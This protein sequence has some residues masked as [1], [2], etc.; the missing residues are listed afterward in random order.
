MGEQGHIKVH[1]PLTFPPAVT[2]FR[3]GDE[4]KTYNTSYDGWGFVF[5]AQEAMRCIKQ[6]LAE[7]PILPLSETYSIMR[8]MD[9]LRSEW[10]LKYPGE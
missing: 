9:K 7:S 10:G 5:E 8:T 4:E 1:S 6:Q 2:V 3:S